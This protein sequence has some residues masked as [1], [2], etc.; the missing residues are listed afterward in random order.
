MTTLCMVDLHSSEQPISL[1]THPLTLIRRQ[2]EERCKALHLDD[3][4]TK[5]AVLAA[6]AEREFGASVAAAIE[7]GKRA[8][9]R[10]AQDMRQREFAMSRRPD[11]DGPRAE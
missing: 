9:Q 10:L 5:E 1:F 7:T 11:P 8:A 4:H 6:H 2:I 3:A